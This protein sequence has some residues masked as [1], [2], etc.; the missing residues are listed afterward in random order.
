MSQANVEVLRR[1][2]EAW[3][4]N[5]WEA[6][7]ACYAPDVIVVPPAEWP[8]AET[9]T[10]REALRHQFEQAKAAWEEEWVEVDEIRDL[11]NRILALYRWIGRG[12]SSHVEVEHPIATLHTLRGGRIVRLEYYLDPSKALEAARLDE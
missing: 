2:F 8:E 9:G 12:R 5:D 6:L 3:N 1:A 10:S 7:M 11:G 4:R